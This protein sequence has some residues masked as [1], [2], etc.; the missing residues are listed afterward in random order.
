MIYIK[1]EEDL[2]KYIEVKY[3]K[4]PQF[5]KNMLY[6][7]KYK[8]NKILNKKVCNGELIILPT[9]NKKVIKELKK[10]KN[11]KCWKNICISK[12]LIDNN[13]FIEF[14]NENNLNIMDGKWIL[15]NIVDKIIEF[16]A[17][18]RNESTNT[19]E[20]TFLCNKLDDTI[21]EK[22]KEVCQ[23]VKKCNVITNNQKQY[24]KLEE[25]LYKDLGIVLNVSTNYKKTAEKSIIIIN[26]DFNHLQ[27]Q[28][29]SFNQDA[30]I[31]NTNKSIDNSLF[32]SKNIIYYKMD[33]PKKY[34]GLEKN[35]ENFDTNSL[36]ESLIYKNTNYKNIK[37]ELIQDGA[38][39][40]YLKNSEEK[41]IKKTKENLP[42]M[43]DKI[44]N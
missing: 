31:I 6:K 17:E 20:I 25:R 30:Y 22:V 26:F 27:F 23:I 39:I 38:R 44:T 2:Y 16:I 4:I 10:M 19:Y 9:I 42:K 24:K 32:D 1:L 5:L 11:I 33:L 7:I 28:K 43:L 15:K 14:V 21:V 29:C 35:F 8:N 13:E 18:S 36:Y 40:V 41:I 34:L 3:E 37:K 12:N